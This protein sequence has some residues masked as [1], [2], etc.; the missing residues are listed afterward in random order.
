ME[1]PMTRQR[2]ESELLEWKCAFKGYMR[3]LYVRHPLQM[4]G[5]LPKISFQFVLET[6]HYAH[7]NMLNTSLKTGIILWFT[8]IN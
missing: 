6:H 5:L 2:W 8:D 1:V 7:Q 3:S 4:H